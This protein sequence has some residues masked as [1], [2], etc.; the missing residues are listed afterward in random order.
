MYKRLLNLLHR[1]F[2]RPKAAPGE[3]AAQ[4][5]WLA[6]VY[7]E[8]KSTSFMV[9]GQR[10][11]H[12]RLYLPPRPDASKRLPLL[13]MLHGCSQTAVE[14]AEGTRMNAVAG[15]R[16]WAVLYPEQS[17]RSNTLRCWNWFAPEVL[18][19]SGEAAL[20]IK[21]VHHVMDHHVIDPER[22][23]VAGMSAGGAMAAVLCATHAERFAACA[24]H[25]GIMFH[26][27][28]TPLQAFEVMRRGAGETVSML[29]K[30][31]A[32]ARGGQVPTL[33]IHGAADEVVNPLN[34]E[35]LLEQMRLLAARLDPQ[36]TLTLGEEVWVEG[37]G[38]RYRQRDLYQG[39][40]LLVRLIMIEG[41]QH[42]WSGG[43]AKHRF[44]DPA[45]PDASEQIVEFLLS[46]HRAPAGTSQAG[47]DAAL[48]ASGAAPAPAA[49]A[50]G[51]VD[52]QV[53]RSL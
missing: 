22:V 19:G 15:A 40:E 49:N 27:A 46:Y 1:R 53:H 23:Y 48:A 16:G 35:H 26:A 9:L 38:R 44:F 30:I 2:G 32:G 12:Y 4:G 42:A 51:R 17:K 39:S 45:G 13:V 24:I 31:V 28:T 21:C 18:A 14:F 8:P 47:S 43:D 41:L 52:G 29:D 37:S 25:S 20:L 11:L 6:S 5:Q 34:A 3:R 10:S 7:H 50:G 36:T 33:L